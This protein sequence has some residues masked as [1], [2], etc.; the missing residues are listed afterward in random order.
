MS[1]KPLDYLPAILE[2]FATATGKLM[3]SNADYMQA[4]E[5]LELGIPLS[6]VQRGI[7]DKL[8]RTGVKHYTRTMPL[9]WCHHD[10]MQVHADW[11]RAVGPSRS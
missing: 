11:R 2:E 7:Q 10:V 9:S 6:C 5:W 3:A 8:S 1:A 4:K